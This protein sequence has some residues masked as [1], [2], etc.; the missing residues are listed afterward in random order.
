MGIHWFLFIAAIV[1]AAQAWIFRSFGAQKLSYE[2]YFNV[3]ACYPGDKVEMV[4]R[5]S[6]HSPLPVPWLRL[7][8]L[9]HGNLKFGQQFNLD[10]SDGTMFQ[11]HRSFFSLMP[12]TKITRRH[13]I[14]CLER[15]CYR[16]R[17]ATLTTGDI[18]GLHKT[19]RQLTVDGE[20][21]VYPRPIPLEEIDL[22]TH[23]WQGDFTVRRW[24]VDDPFMIAGAREYRTGDPLKG[25][26]WKAT[27][28]SGKL[29]VHQHDFTAEHRLLIYYNVEDHEGMWDQVNNVA[30]MEKGISYA[31]AFAE[32]AIERGMDVGFGTNAHSI[33]DPSEP[34]RVVPMS[35]YAQLEYMLETMAKLIVAR[36]LP[37]DYF[38][39]EEVERAVSGMDIL[40]ISTHV[41]DKMLGPMEQLR[42]NGNAVNVFLLQEDEAKPRPKETEVGA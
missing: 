16:L 20:L 41:S 5:L 10:I 37:F 22:P 19:S 31:A 14:T 2:R 40:I 24:I 9:I 1:I 32:L 39:D 36:C 33:D 42:R 3:R 35:G 29:Q 13:K 18:I 26:N 6:N 27:A 12:F 30:L 38:L 28:R 17:T 23:S 11:N 8:S 15:G 25:V 34:V 7:E 4:E 21:L